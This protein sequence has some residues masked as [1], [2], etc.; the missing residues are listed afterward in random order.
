MH[1]SRRRARGQSDIAHGMRH[2][3]RLPGIRLVM[4]RET[5]KLAFF[6]LFP[7]RLPQF[8]NMA[9]LAFLPA[10]SERRY[11]RHDRQVRPDE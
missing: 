10:T 7:A 1:F 8:V 6:S 3:P 5:A 4:Q 11:E 9:M 2:R